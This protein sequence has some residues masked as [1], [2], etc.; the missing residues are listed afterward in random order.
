MKTQRPKAGE[1]LATRAR[2][3]AHTAVAA[4]AAMVAGTSAALAAPEA[5][6]LRIDP[7]VASQDGTPI[8]TTVVDLTQ[9]HPID[10]VFTKAGCTNLKGGARHDCMATAMEQPNALFDTV[11][12]PE[13]DARLTVSIP[14]EDYPRG[15]LL[16]FPPR[17]RLTD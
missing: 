3:A 9:P 16:F 4:M 17:T 10:Q 6:I 13:G 12:F 8:L 11:A 14:P 1:G 15:T 7:R 2:R 5:H